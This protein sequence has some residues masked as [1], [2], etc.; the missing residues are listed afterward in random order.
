MPRADQVMAGSN[1]LSCMVHRDGNMPRLSWKIMKAGEKIK[2]KG[3][4]TGMFKIS[5]ADKGAK[6]FLSLSNQAE[7]NRDV[8]SHFVVAVNSKFLHY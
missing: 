7:T 1:V 8:N 4:E 2:G 6:L 5:L 3:I